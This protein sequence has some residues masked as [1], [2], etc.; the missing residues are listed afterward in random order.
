ME[1][2]TK[3]DPYN[4]DIFKSP[5]KKTKPSVMNSIYDNPFKSNNSIIEISSKNLLKLKNKHN[6]FI[7][8][9]IKKHKKDILGTKPS[10]KPDFVFDSQQEDFNLTLKEIFNKNTITTFKPSD[11]GYTIEPVTS[12]KNGFITNETF[13]Y[14]KIEEPVNAGGSIFDSVLYAIKSNV[15]ES[16][17]QTFEYL[18]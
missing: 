17:G 7:Q 8:P 4:A 15:N 2:S 12:V 10:N 3:T 5:V 13:K 16:N 11:G 1:I 14:V 6:V 18:E 9:K